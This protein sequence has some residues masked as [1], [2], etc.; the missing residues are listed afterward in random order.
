VTESHRSGAI[1]VDT[2]FP[3]SDAPCARID[4]SFEDSAM[5]LRV[6]DK[7]RNYRSTTWKIAID[8]IS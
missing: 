5:G 8:T 3:T 2:P 4:G 1:A 7:G 6:G